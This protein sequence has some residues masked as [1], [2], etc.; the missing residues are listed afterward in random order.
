MFRKIVLLSLAMAGLLGLAACGGPRVHIT[1][2]GKVPGAGREA[3]LVRLINLQR[4][5]AGLAPLEA[6]GRLA[7]AAQAHAGAMA[8]N[9]CVDFDCGGRQPALRVSDAGYRA[10]TSRFYV[11]AGHAGPEQM[12]RGMMGQNWGRKMILD[13]SFRHVAVG[14]AASAGSYRHFWA[15]GFAVPAMEDRAVL[16]AEVLRLVNI[17]RAKHGAGPLVLNPR[18]NKSAQF[19]ADFMA[20]NDCFEHLCPGEPELGERVR[21]AGYDWQRVAE[22]IAAGQEDPAEVVESW[23][24][25]PGHRRNI[26]NPALKEIG[27]GYTLLDQDGGKESWRHYW[28]QN[29]GSQG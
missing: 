4:K 14:Y 23:M 29:F 5:K 3:E 11:A 8:A 1:D 7:T 13:G 19:H 21:R 15:V 12:L 27:V 20:G 25:S 17:E 18:L 24:N 6:D 28:V 9:A 16:A 22:N 2:E 26:L 10:R